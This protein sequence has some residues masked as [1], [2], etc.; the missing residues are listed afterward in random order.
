MNPAALFKIKGAWQKFSNNHPR[1]VPF[2]N[3]AN[4]KGITKEK[5]SLPSKNEWA[6]FAGKLEITE[7]N[8]STYGLSSYYWTST[9]NYSDTSWYI[10]FRKYKIFTMITSSKIPIRLCRTF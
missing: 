6:A 1:L 9:V 2:L 10:N 5:W 8:Y 4:A 3:A 7:S